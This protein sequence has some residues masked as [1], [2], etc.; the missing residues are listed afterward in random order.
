MWMNASGEVLAEGR[1]HRF[2]TPTQRLAA[3]VEQ[4][5]CQHEGCDVPGY[6]CHF[7]HKI[8]WSKGGGTDLRTTQLLCP[9]HHARAHQPGE[10]PMRT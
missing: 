9:Y 6:L 2:H 1:H 5:H 10:D 4:L 7:H 3:I 8:P